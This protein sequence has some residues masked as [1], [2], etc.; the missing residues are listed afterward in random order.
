MGTDKINALKN[1]MCAHIH[2]H[3]KLMTNLSS[4]TF[5]GLLCETHP[6]YR[7]YYEKLIKSANETAKVANNNK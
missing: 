1:E 5:E 2:S 3:N 6:L 4:F 7:E